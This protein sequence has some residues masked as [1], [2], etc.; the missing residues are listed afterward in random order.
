VVSGGDKPRD[1]TLVATGSEVGL[2]AE[3]AAALAKDG[4]NAAVVS[5]PSFELFRA[6]PQAYRDAVLGDAPRIAV[7]AAVAQ[8]WYEWMRPGDRFIGL[9]DFGASAPGPKV[10]EHFG[11]TAA[12]VADTARAFAKKS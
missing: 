3:A 6:E 11:L 1:V 2:V 9:S 5:L 12:K 7:E 10:F 4:I 8:P